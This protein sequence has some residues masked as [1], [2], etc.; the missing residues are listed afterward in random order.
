MQFRPHR[1]KTFPNESRK[2]WTSDGN[3]FWWSKA[4]EKNSP[5]LSSRASGAVTSRRGTYPITHLHFQPAPIGRGIFFFFA[6][7]VPVSAPVPFF[8]LFYPPS[9]QQVASHNQPWATGL[10]LRLG[11]RPRVSV[12]VDQSVSAVHANATQ[13]VASHIPPKQRAIQLPRASARV[14]TSICASALSGN[15]DRPTYTLTKLGTI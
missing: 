4:E 2:C 14:P 15:L 1:S 3:T 7:T 8:L 13:V 12:Q 11:A 10:W 5:W 9:R 6:A